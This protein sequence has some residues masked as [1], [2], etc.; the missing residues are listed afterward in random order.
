MLLLAGSIFIISMAFEKVA[1]LNFAEIVSG[2]VGFGAII[3][4]MKSL[5]SIMKDVKF[6]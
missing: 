1:K 3:I 2:V 6:S 4:G 5:L